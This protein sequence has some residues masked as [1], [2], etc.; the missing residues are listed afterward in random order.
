MVGYWSLYIARGMPLEGVPILSEFINAGLAL[1]T[2]YG[3]FTLRSWAL[4]T[5]FVLSGMWIY[6]VVGGLNMV[7][8]KGLDFSSP[9]GALS[10]TI[11]FR[12]IGKR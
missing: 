3:I 12:M 7:I 5:G 10:D 1:L 6:G 9:I 8:D 2:G 11:I 4:M